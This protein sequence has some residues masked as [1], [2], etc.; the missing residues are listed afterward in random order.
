MPD[1]GGP[2]NLS[3]QNLPNQNLSGRELSA[4]RHKSSPVT[5]KPALA[6][7]I[8]AEDGSQLAVL[9]DQAVSAVKQGKSLS[10]TGPTGVFFTPRPLGKSGKTAF[11]YPGSGNHYPGMGQELSISFPDILDAMDR[12]GASLYKRV[13]PD[14]FHPRRTSWEKGWKGQALEAIESHAHHMIF[15]QVSFG[16]LMTR[17][18]EKLGLTPRAAIGHSLGETA[19]LFALGVW[20]NPEEMLTRMEASDLFTRRLAGEFSLLKKAWN[21]GKNEK[22]QWSVAAVN[23]NRKAV[24][25]RLREFDRLYLLIVNTPGE[26]VIGGSRDQMEKFIAKERCGALFLKGV[27]S[28]HCPLAAA[29]A[30]SYLDLHRFPCRPRPDITFYGCHGGMPHETETETLAKSILNQALEGFDYPRLINRAH[31]D[32]VRI[33]IEMG[34][35]ASCTRAVDQILKD[36]THLAVSFSSATEPENLALL[37]ALAC[38]AGHRVPMDLDPWFQR[39]K[40][41]GEIDHPGLKP[42]IVIPGQ[43]SSGIFSKMSSP[44]PETLPVQ[45]PSWNLT[46]KLQDSVASTGR[47]HTRFLELTRDNTEAMARQLHCLAGLTDISTSGTPVA[48]CPSVSSTIPGDT[49]T[50]LSASP[51]AHEVSDTHEIPGIP[52]AAVT[53]TPAEPRP[54]LDRDQCLEFAVGSAGRVL[55]RAFEEI[56]QYPVRVRLP[57]EPLMLVD[58]IMAIEGEMLSL[59]RGKIITQHDVRAGAWYLDGG[60]TPV[61]IS[62]EAGQADLFLSSWLGID[63]RVKGKRR[64]RLLDAKVTF[65]R[66]LPMPGETIEYRIEIDRFLKQGEVYLFFFHYEGFIGDERL[67]SMRDGCAGFFTPEEVENSGGI[68]LKNEE[69]ARR[70]PDRPFTPLA[71]AQ[72]VSLMDHQVEALRRGDLTEAFGPTFPQF[73]LGQGIRLPGGRMHLIDRVTL[74]DPHGGRFGMGLIEAEADIRPDHW[75]LTCHFIDDKVMPGTLMYECCAHALRIFTQRMG[76]IG[77]DNDL[78][79]DIIPGLES[80]LKCRGP[81]TPETRKAGYRIEIKEMGYD[82][83]PYVIADAHMFS[84]NHRIVLYKNMGMKLAGRDRAYFERIWKKP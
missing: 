55:G 11:L 7:A 41:A 77:P 38:L 83:E 3:G 48:P 73:P 81:V 37:K 13:R 9:A 39:I 66:T 21:L 69:L 4:I 42:I 68:I 50:D 70:I 56:D 29:A 62:I 64:Y 35:G 18:T 51:E 34:P 16:L 28:V 15:G 57:G 6:A 63:H 31:D 5:G 49:V 78:H 46:Q 33:F 24:E 47:A 71:P 20:E 74:L 79:Y 1:Q 76:W 59:T 22:P 14:L 58:R 53:N 26:C 75:F 65:H 40:T 25:A 67:I 12:E 36:K 72:K 80:D 54:M 10:I 27:V 84:D 60:R 32:G 45:S 23:R 2:Q 82:P 17:I 43:R 8:I 52:D 44:A 61:S 19:S 30:E